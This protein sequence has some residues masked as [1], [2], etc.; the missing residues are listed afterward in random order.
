MSALA[1]VKHKPE[2]HPLLTKPESLIA[3]AAHSGVVPAVQG[4]TT[5]GGAP[6]NMQERTTSTIAATVPLYVLDDI[7]QQPVSLTSI[8]H[9]YIHG[10]LNT[11][12]QCGICHRVPLHPVTPECCGQVSCQECLGRWVRE[13][14]ANVKCPYCRE[15]CGL[16]N[17]IQ[18]ASFVTK[19]I[20][21]LMVKCPHAECDD[22]PTIGKDG[23]NILEHVTK[24]CDALVSCTDCKKSLKRSV[25][26][27]HKPD[28]SPCLQM[29]LPCSVCACTI[30]RMDWDAHLQSTQ[31]HSASTFKCMTLL[32]ELEQ[33][34]VDLDKEKVASTN[35]RAELKEISPLITNIPATTATKLQAVDARYDARVAEQFIAIDVQMYEFEIP[36]WSEFKELTK[37]TSE[38]PL[39]IWGHE[40]YLKIEK[41]GTRIG[42]YLCCEAEGNFPVS[43]D[44]QLMLRKRN[45]D[46]G[47]CAS[48]VF[49]TEF[50]KEK[51][52]GLANFTSSETME[53]EG[54][55]SRTE[56]KVTFG[57]K[58]IPV[59]GLKWGR[60]ANRPSE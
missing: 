21:T 8:D 49:R 6:R 25:Y 18:P 30:P 56:D 17:Q 55:Y 14:G 35:N 31:H 3:T 47:V 50:G 37:Y 5:S 2:D 9:E 26:E 53:R 32:K 44:Y 20:S 52:W 46:L 48:V 33:L 42:L 15:P 57:C 58:I 43:V 7:S 38:K 41:E 27:D 24:C 12:Y 10:I 40:W 29:P 28:S 34:Q 36:K 54:A 19:M 22:K 60:Y 11:D 39:K 51:A 23:R 16:P 13:Q 45:D 4:T 1:E 59:K